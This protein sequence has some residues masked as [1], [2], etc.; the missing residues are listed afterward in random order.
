MRWKY[1]GLSLLLIAYSI[2]GLAIDDI[3]SPGKR[4]NPGL[5]FHG[6]PALLLGAAML[7]AALNM[8]S[9]VIDHYDTR[10]NEINYKQ[11]AR[12]T[13]IVGWCLVAL[14]VILKFSVFKPSLL[15]GAPAP[16][17]SLQA[18]PGYFLAAESPS[19]RAI[20]SAMYGRTL[21]GMLSHT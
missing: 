14:A 5:H 16:N 18:T 1:L 8:L 17:V 10:D 7:T 13:Q 2:L 4:A 20:Q 19:C 12:W 11:F 21:Y 6:V 3:Y 9:V 15:P